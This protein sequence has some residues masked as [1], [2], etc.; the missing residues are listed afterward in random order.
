MNLNLALRLA[1]TGWHILPL[2][3]A[4]KRPLS[5]C[6]ACRTRGHTIDGCACIPAG[7][8][9]HGVRAATTDPDRLRSWWERVPEAVPAVAAGPSRLVLLDI[10]AHNEPLPPTLATGLLPGIDLR[11]EQLHRIEWS[12]ITRWQDG[13]DTLRLLARVRG[14]PCPWP[15]DV[16]H[17][18]VVAVTPSG[19]R[20]LWY[21]VPDGSGDLRQALSDPHGRS[22]L[23]W[24]IDVKAGYSYGIAP[25]ACTK[26]GWYEQRSGDIARPG[27][28]PGWLAH[29]VRRAAAVDRRSTPPRTHAVSAP[30]TGSGPAAYIT[31]VIRRGASELTGLRDGRQ[32][33]LAALAYKVGGYL[34]W[35]GCSPGQV[36]KELV[37]AGTASGLSHRLAERIVYRSL[38]RGV[39]E[40]LPPPNQRTT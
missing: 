5:L 33:A 26:S 19:G 10:D 38:E 4:S 24:Q 2:S 29:E 20:H 27:A 12:D 39:A 22:G 1:A 21:R 25:G 23:G 16:T 9:C 18:P 8:W 15:G 7:R 40:P 28:M 14:G 30:G 13:R 17:Q 11:T 34:I 3:P 37:A 6:P 32:R 36:Q 35:S 31:T